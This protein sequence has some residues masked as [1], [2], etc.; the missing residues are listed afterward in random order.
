MYC[1]EDCPQ[2]T[3]MSMY[4]LILILNIESNVIKKIPAVNHAANI[5]A[6]NEILLG[7]IFLLSHQKVFNGINESRE[8][9]KG[10]IKTLIPKIDEAISKSLPIFPETKSTIRL[11]TAPLNARK[12]LDIP[13]NVPKSLNILLF[14]KAL[15][16]NNPI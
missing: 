2:T 3:Q 12:L 4:H 13:K 16:I 15:Y 5:M 8:K 6:A 11:I 7:A 9:T 1:P 10:S 14:M